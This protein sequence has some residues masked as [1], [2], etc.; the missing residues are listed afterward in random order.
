MPKQ[1][2]VRFGELLTRARENQKPRMNQTQA[3]SRLTALTGKTFTQSRVALLEGGKITDPKPELIRALVTVYGIPFRDFIKILAE[4]KYGL[5]PG[6]AQIAAMSRLD[7]EGLSAWMKQLPDGQ[8]VWFTA[9]RLLRSAYDSV[10]AGISSVL[11]RGGEVVVWVSESDSGAKSNT[12]RFLLMLRYRHKYDGTVLRTAL[13]DDLEVALLTDYVIANP[14]GV[15]T[16]TGNSEGWLAFVRQ[17]GLLCLEMPKDMLEEQVI[18]TE[19]LVRTRAKP[20]DISLI[21]R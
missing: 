18:K 20:V 16:G 19:A 9:P 10:L 12:H 15:L 8:S 4:E 1:E 17:E 14:L 3:A 7:A 13:I 11:E 2:L 21:P 5:T 6:Q